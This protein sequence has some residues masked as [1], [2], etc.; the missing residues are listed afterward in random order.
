MKHMLLNGLT[1]C[2]E[3]IM[4]Q[5]QGHLNIKSGGETATCIEQSWGAVLAEGD[6]VCYV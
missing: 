3:R 5:S 6:S 1:V 2:T 4:S